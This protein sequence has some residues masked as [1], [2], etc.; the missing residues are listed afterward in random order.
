MMSFNAMPSIH[1][2]IRYAEQCAAIAEEPHNAAYRSLLLEMAE[3]WRD[4]AEQ[5]AANERPLERGGG[6]PRGST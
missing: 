4:L 5:H 6:K 1:R 3:A 2:Y